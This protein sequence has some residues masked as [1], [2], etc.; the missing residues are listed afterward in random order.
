VIY[1]NSSTNTYQGSGIS[2][3]EP[4]VA[5]GF[6]ATAADN[7]T[8]HIV[9]S[10]NISHDNMET[11]SCGG[12]AG[13]HT[14]GEGI[15]IDTTNQSAGTNTPYPNQILVLGNLVYNN[16]GRGVQVGPN[17]SNTTVANNTAYN[18]NL[19][20]NDSATWRGEIANATSSNNV[21]VNNIGYAVVG[22]GMMSNN[23]SLFTG[24]A[25]SAT[26][27][28]NNLGYGGPVVSST[29]DP[30][31]AANKNQIGVDPKLAN[32][33]SDNFVPM[34][35]SPVVGAGVPESYV[36]VSAPDIGAY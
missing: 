29:K 35:G 1:E 8:F 20:T 36:P 33:A 6:P 2:V 25:T 14:D 11:Y 31:V 12:S 5:T 9:V 19:D 24:D 18:D 17:S 4:G 7:T 13:C 34:S 26:P 27:W 28:E 16:G 10:Y 15:I 21:F 3:W 23:S 30:I 22:T 32:V